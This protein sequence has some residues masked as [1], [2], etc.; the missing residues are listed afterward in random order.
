MELERSGLREL[1]LDVVLHVGQQNWSLPALPS[2]LLQLQPVKGGLA[3]EVSVLY[4][5]F[6]KL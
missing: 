6:W 1:S 5:F 3:W 4:P 2:Q